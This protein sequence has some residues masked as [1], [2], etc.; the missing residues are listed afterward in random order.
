ML[1]MNNFTQFIKLRPE[2]HPLGKKGGGI[3]VFVRNDFYPSE[4][5]VPCLTPLDEILWLCVRPKVLPHPFNLIVL[6]CFY[7]SPGQRAAE[8]IN[9]IEKLHGNADYVLSKYPNA[10]IFLLGDANDLKLESTC[11]TFSLKTNC[12]SPYYQR[13]F[14]S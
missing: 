4:I 7:Y 12:K 3:L 5:L 9:F 11:N 6:C 13:Q 10:G 1:K 2:T 14:Y 8:K